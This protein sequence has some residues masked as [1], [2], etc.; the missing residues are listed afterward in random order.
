[1]HYDTLLIT[2]IVQ[3]IILFDMQHCMGYVPCIVTP[4]D[5]MVDASCYMFLAKTEFHRIQLSVKI[6]PKPES[7]ILVLKNVFPALSPKKIMLRLFHSKIHHNPMESP[8]IQQ[9]RF[10]FPWFLQII[11]I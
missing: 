4:T 8:G 5:K 3:G 1:V 7:L 9:L 6:R 10:C 2:A 11:I